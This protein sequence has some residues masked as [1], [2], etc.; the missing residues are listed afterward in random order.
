MNYSKII[1][2]LIVCISSILFTKA[3]DQWAYAI[4]NNGTTAFM[5]NLDLDSAYYIDG[6]EINN[7]QFLSSQTS[8]YNAKTN[9]ITALGV[10]TVSSDYYYLYVYTGEG[11]LPTPA[12]MNFPKENYIISS[13]AS[14]QTVDQFNYF[15][16]MVISGLSNQNPVG[17][18]SVTK[19]APISNNYKVVDVIS[20]SFSSSAYNWGSQ[21]FNVVFSNASG[22]FVN[23]YTQGG[24]L[25]SSNKYGILSTPDNYNVA[26]SPYNSV[27]IPMTNLVYSFI[28]LVQTYTKLSITDLFKL[29]PA[30]NKFYDMGYFSNSAFR[31]VSTKI[32]AMAGHTTK[33]IFYFISSTTN[34]QLYPSGIVIDTYKISTT[35]NMLSSNEFQHPPINM[36]TY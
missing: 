32:Y 36:W 27:Y 8:T 15:S 16:T 31:V 7:F 10:S 12:I 19:L 5:G 17:T 2:T 24:Q 11:W 13:I 29:Y 14:D 3:Q 4:W 6:V 35:G 34:L 1:V 23:I 9:E 30:N 25:Q 20:G 18:F 22:L 33:Q 26:S 21:T 28:D